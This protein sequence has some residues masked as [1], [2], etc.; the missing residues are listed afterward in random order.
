MA[1]RPPRGRGEVAPSLLVDEELARAIRNESALAVRH[2]WRVSMGVVARWRKALGVGRMD[3]P[4][5][6]RLIQAAVEQGAQALRDK[7]WTEEEREERRRLAL[8]QNFAANLAPGY[9]G[10]LWTD[11]ERSL[12]G[13]MPD[14]QVA[15][16]IG[17]TVEAIR[18]ERTRRGIASA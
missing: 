2:W 15:A 1:A 17:R 7:V 9:H 8:A 11:E 6:A 12:L 14:E 18:L 10:A 3:S 5:S 4:G 13:T 16:R